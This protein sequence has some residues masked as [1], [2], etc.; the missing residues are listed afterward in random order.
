MRSP[1]AAVLSLGL[2]VVPACSDMP[3]GPSGGTTMTIT[4]VTPESP[5]RDNAPQILFVEGRN[6]LTG[7]ILFV[8]A[9]DGTDAVVSGANIQNVQSSSF[10]ARVVLSQSGTYELRVGPSPGAQSAPFQILVR[11]TATAP[12]I[13]SV[14]PASVIR[15]P[16]VQVVTF[17]GLNFDP[18]LEVTIVEPDGVVLKIF[19]TQMLSLSSTLVQFS[20]VFTKAG[21]YTFVVTNPSGEVSNSVQITSI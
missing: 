13:F 18:N 10:E 12:A 15:G 11:P 7:P 2:I 16:A 5:V 4:E 6:F 14:T 1:A 9:P 19:A 21:L 17:D 20:K 3:A 8:K